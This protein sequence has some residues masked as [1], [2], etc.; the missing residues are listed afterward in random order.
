MVEA[1]KLYNITLYAIKVHREKFV[2]N[3]YNESSN[4]YSLLTNLTVTKLRKI[5]EQIDKSS[6][7]EVVKLGNPAK[8]L[9]DS[10]E[11]L[12][13]CLGIQEPDVTVTIQPKS[14]PELP[15]EVIQHTA[16][17]KD[18]ILK[19]SSFKHS[20]HS[21]VAVVVLIPVG[22]PGMGKTS[23]ATTHLAPAIAK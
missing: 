13:V 9:V 20:H 8:I 2:K 1:Q 11:D 16:V 23:L 5:C 4:F 7:T 19:E 12:L 15:R 6:K 10:E 22:L 17:T 18:P 3:Y 21:P 14:E